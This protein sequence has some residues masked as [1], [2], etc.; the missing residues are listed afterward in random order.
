M[1]LYLDMNTCPGTTFAVRQ[2][3]G[4]NHDPKKLHG[5][6]V[7]SIIHYLAK[8]KDNSNIIEPSSLPTIHMYVGAQILSLLVPTQKWAFSSTLLIALFESSH[9]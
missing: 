6:S 8:I 7:K 2:V 9:V 4:L 5:T 3:A 1:I